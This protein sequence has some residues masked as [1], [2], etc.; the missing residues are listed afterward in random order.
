MGCM[1]Q[2]TIVL[3]QYATQYAEEELVNELLLRCGIILKCP[4]KLRTPKS[5]QDYAIPMIVRLL[6]SNKQ[7]KK[8]KQ[9][10]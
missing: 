9:Q 4:Q 7:K 10:S 2:Y 1:V 5:V 8:V 6:R 3:S